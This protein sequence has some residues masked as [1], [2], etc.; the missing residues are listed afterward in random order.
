MD[1]ER[2]FDGRGPVLVTVDWCE[3]IDDKRA[4]D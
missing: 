4:A 1:S 3:A 2:A